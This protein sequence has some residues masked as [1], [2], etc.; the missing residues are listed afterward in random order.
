MEIFGLT[1]DRGA[2]LMAI[3]N[4]EATARRKGETWSR[5]TNTERSAFILQELNK[6][7]WFVL[8]RLDAD[9]ARR[10]RYAE[11]RSDQ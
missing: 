8:D 1:P 6:L 9:R 4:A 11:I 2:L 10:A 5:L 3:E 7:G